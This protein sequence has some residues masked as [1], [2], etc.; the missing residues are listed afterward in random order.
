MVQRD[1]EQHYLYDNHDDGLQQQ[2]GIEPRAGPVKD[3][4]MQETTVS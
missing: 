3:P 2:T 4:V 1:F